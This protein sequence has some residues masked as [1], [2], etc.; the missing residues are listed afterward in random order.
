[1]NW[2]VGEGESF[3]RRRSINSNWILSSR[4]ESRII[5]LWETFMRVF[6]SA[7]LFTSERLFFSRGWCDESPKGFRVM[8][9]R[10]KRYLQ[11]LDRANDGACQS[12]AYQMSSV[13]LQSLWAI[14][15]N[16]ASLL[17]LQ[18]EPLLPSLL[19]AQ[20]KASRIYFSYGHICRRVACERGQR[21]AK[22]MSLDW[23]S[24]CKLS[25]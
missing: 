20:Q 23:L 21:Y 10:R 2:C 1:M 6:L 17:E 7:L 25:C 16:L 9:K 24:R 14:K 3:A 18:M 15:N 22:F 12:S 19:K 5:S 4:S 8:E 11:S 13:K